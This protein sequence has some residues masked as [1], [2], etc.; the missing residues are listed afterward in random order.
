MRGLGPSELKRQEQGTV[1]PRTVGSR[2]GEINRGI[3]TAGTVFSFQVDFGVFRYV[4]LKHLLEVEHGISRNE[5]VQ[6]SVR[7][8]IETALVHMVAQGVRDGSWRLK[9]PDDIHKPL[10]QAYLTNYDEQRLD[11]PLTG[12]DT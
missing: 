6:Q 10:L 11:M 8:A 4:S 5:P 12:S 2:S 9:N 1:N 3:T 7:E